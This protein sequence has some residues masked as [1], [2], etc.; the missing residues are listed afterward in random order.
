MTIIDGLIQRMDNS[1]GFAGLGESLQTVT[2]L[3]D[4]DDVEIRD[5]ATAILRDASLT[6][7]LLSIANSSRYGQGGRNVSTIKQAIAIVGL[8]T[9][10]SVALSLSLLNALSNKPQ[11]GLLHAEIVAAY[12]CGMLSAEITRIQSPRFNSQEAQVCGLMQN[13]GRMMALYYLYEDIERVYDAQIA[14]NLT[15]EIAVKEVLGSSFEEI[16]AAIAKHWTLPDVLQ[17]SLEPVTAKAPPQAPANAAGWN[18][19]C[20]MF[21]RR[22]T[23]SIFRLPENRETIEINRDIEFF[24]SALSLK[25]LE[26]HEW[27]SDML[28]A[29]DAMLADMSF[30]CNME[31]AR[32]L[33][34]KASERVQNVVSGQDSLTKGSEKFAGRSPLEVIQ[35]VLRLAHDAC[36]F[37][38]TLLCLP[39]GAAG[40]RAIAGVGRNVNQATANFRCRGMAPDIFRLVMAKKV[41]MYIADVKAPAIAKLLPSW[42]VDLVNGRSFLLVSLVHEGQFLGM[43]YGDY[44]E[45]RPDSPQ[46]LAK[47]KLNDWREQ[48]IQALRSSSAKH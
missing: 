20:T 44:T 12:F 35:H 13:L 14:N 28:E 32:T 38:L 41:D 34:R 6:G 2:R 26:V 45:P 36:G 48:L 11:S 1:P 40:M 10:K 39:E 27:I 24:R 8:K 21:A 29:T 17:K 33:L 42:Y 19:V 43:L 16:G 30:P 25:E 31:E 23:D 37:D 3:S 7:K 46:N 15:E 47:H 18:Q 4:A 9:V 22:V 5:L